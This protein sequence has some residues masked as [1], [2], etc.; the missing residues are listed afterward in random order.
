MLGVA[1]QDRCCNDKFGCGDSQAGI[2]IPLLTL[3]QFLACYSILSS[4]KTQPCF[5]QSLFLE[6]NVLALSH[7]ASAPACSHH[8]ISP[9]QDF[10]P[11][12]CPNPSFPVKTSLL[13]RITTCCLSTSVG[14]KFHLFSSLPYCSC[15]L[16]FSLQ[17]LPGAH[18][19]S[20]IPLKSW[21]HVRLCPKYRF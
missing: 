6:I 1:A 17:F 18:R 7:D 16:F 2:W 12:V 8:W 20:S 3:C 15:T 19:I 21:G 14:T 5:Y 9:V 11:L 10:V 4:G 13:A